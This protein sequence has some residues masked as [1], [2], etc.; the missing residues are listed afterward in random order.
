MGIRMSGIASGLDTEAIIAELMKAKS[1][2]KTK[3]EGKKTKLEWQQEKW[4]DLNAKLYKLYTDYASKL[5]MTSGYTLKK[6]STANEGVASVKAA[7]GA[8]TGSYTMKVN[9]LATSQ[10]VTGGKIDDSMITGG[11]KGSTKLSALDPNMVG[12]EITIANGSKV[13]SLQIKDGTTINDLVNAYQTVGLT[14]SFDEGQKRFFISSKESGADSQ[15]SMVVQRLDE[16]ELEA[17]ALIE[18]SVNFSKL[19]TA[20][21]EKVSQLYDDLREPEDSDRYNNAVEALKKIATKNAEAAAK[22]D[23]TK[24]VKEELYEIVAS[25]KEE[26]YLSTIGLSYFET[27]EGGE[28]SLKEEVR[29]KIYDDLV[30]E[31]KLV[32]DEPADEVDLLI[33][34]RATEMMQSDFKGMVNKEVDK[35]VKEQAWQDEINTFVED[36]KEDY[37]ATAVAGVDTAV[38]DYRAA[39]GTSSVEADAF[40]AIG[41][42]TLDGSAVSGTTT[43]ASGMSTV[44]AQDSIIELNGALLTSNS[45]T[46]NANGLTIELK[47]EGN[48]TFSVANDT[49]GV[50][51]T[52]KGFLKEY[53]TIMA[54]MN[55]LLRAKSARGY[56]P[57]TDEE[58]EAMSE[59]QIELWESKIKD[60]LFRNDDTLRGISSAMR[61]AMMS[62][63]EV[64]GEK[65]SLI[66][67]GIMTSSD[68]R[69]GGLLHIF[70]D[71][72]DSTYM[73]K[74][75]KLMKMLTE[76]PD[77]A[78]AIMKGVMSN[79]SDTMFDKMKTSPLSSALTFYKDKQM[80]KQLE[81]YED[82]IKLWTG[83][84]A[85]IEDRYF[86]QFTAMEKAMAKINSQSSTFA[87]MS[88]MGQ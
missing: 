17:R 56:E 82:D 12:S 3:I 20:D 46:V 7:G 68:Y 80:N 59:K 58:K 86:K 62:S 77:K 33:E 57:L 31:G 49:E 72:D 16:A 2:K 64:D 87:S 79:L 37:I 39:G 50:Y 81:G 13:V 78:I 66:D 1:M 8:T 18:E 47:A 19:S 54:E 29:T 14:A 4:V 73:D 11:V 48:T 41:L 70:G 25:E 35:R 45:T 52:F 26:E 42:E 69:E 84:L 83:R 53:N 63:V 51:N 5:S 15:F 28:A 76:D 22:A 21:K 55:T 43:G 32:G 40:Y 61:N 24:E 65:Y 36:N 71:V 75:D 85:D 60:S 74:D 30:A 67:L 6:T 34:E 9:Q 88:G 38:A 44:A 23:G 27:D 10:Y